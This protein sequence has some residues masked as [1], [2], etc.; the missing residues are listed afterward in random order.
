MKTETTQKSN[1][2]SC[3]SQRRHVL[4]RPDMYISSINSQINE[5]VFLFDDETEKIINKKKIFVNDGIIRIFQE[6]LSNCIDNYERSKHTSTPMTLLKVTYNE[7][8]NEIEFLNDGLSIPI[9][10]YIHSNDDDDDDDTT[11]KKLKDLYIPEVIFGE[12]LTGSNYKKGTHRTTSGRNGVGVKVASI[13]SKQFTVSI[14]DPERQLTYKQVWKD[15][16]KKKGKAIIKKKKE[17]AKTPQKGYTKIAYQLDFSLFDRN[18]K[19]PDGSSTKEPN[20]NDNKSY[21][22]DTIGIFKSFYLMLP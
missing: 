9:E 22:A 13:F 21:N 19:E 8:N 10:K 2:Y 12:L 1:A 7:E 6:V 14:S 5:D 4:E 15:S 17:N 16:M 3:L 18:S 20:D 11:N